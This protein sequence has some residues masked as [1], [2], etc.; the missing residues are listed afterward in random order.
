MDIETQLQAKC[1]YIIFRN[2]ANQYTVARFQRTDE[3][4]EQFT[5][6]GHIPHL[7]TDVTYRLSGTY[8]QH[9]RYGIQF[10][11]SECVRAL[12]DD[13]DALIRFFSGSHFS[14]IGPAMAMRLVDT[15]GNSLCARIREDAACLD[16]VEG[17]TEKKK[18]A[19]LEGLRESGAFDASYA[20]LLAN[21]LSARQIGI[22][23]EHYGDDFIQVLEEDPYRPFFEIDGFG[24]RSC[25]RLAEHYQVSEDDARRQ[26]ALVYD[27][28]IQHCFRSGSTYVQEEALRKTLW[29]QFGFE[30]DEALHVLMEKDVLVLEEGRIYD[31]RQYEAECVIASRLNAPDTRS[32]LP[33]DFDAQLA[34]VQEELNIVYDDSQKAAIRGFFTHSF[35]IL[36]GGPGTGKTT[37][38]RAILLLQERLSPDAEML[39]AAP[40]GRAAKRLSELSGRAAS[41][42]HSLLKW[43][44]ETN[45][46]LVNEK[47][48]LNAD[49]LIVDEFSMVDSLLFAALL[50]A[51]TSHA[52]LLLIGDQN[53]L[54]SVSSGKVL[55]DLI[56]S[57][58]FPLYCLDTIYRQSQGSGIA[59]LAAAIRNE[60]PL[61]FEGDVR[62][63]RCNA[64]QVQQA[65]IQVVK[66]ALDAG[67]SAKDIQVLSP[68]YQ[69]AG[70]IDVLNQVLQD[71]INPA[72][73]FKR[74]LK[75]GYRLF[76]E[77]D[78]VLQLRNMREDAVCN[79]DIGEIVEIIPS[80]ESVDHSAQIVVA[81]DDQIVEY[82]QDTLS[83][84]THAYC[85]SV[86]KSQGNE[87]PVVIMAVLPQHRFMLSRRLLYTGITR[88]RR[89]LVLLGDPQLFAAALKQEEREQRDTTLQLR[90][91]QNYPLPAPLPCE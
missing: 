4:G 38:I 12:P 84:L 9:P 52:R 25:D 19:I 79:G 64:E 63:I 29:Q 36:N 43:D 18:H 73:S 49:A 45:T 80:E 56:E 58:R 5:A 10:Q 59:A 81:F 91:S 26:R 31:H 66:N 53:Q 24:F 46:F 60:D 17:M 88:A 23:E 77:G 39:L 78:K 15:L 85:M 86:H 8:V 57:Q 30:A 90:L 14:G 54:P 87:Y 48:P 1:R 61:S 74:E 44:L 47:D 21:G 27:T 67:Y 40:T 68:R 72:D 33:D 41:T 16:L 83:Y 71:V 20:F 42:L 82:E 89:A 32:A 75:V 55:Q 69:G 35:M 2:E 11:V 6:T 62:F 65:V 7:E 34:A 28:L 37:V 3:N 50:R 76:R 22:L 70:G 13:R 51:M